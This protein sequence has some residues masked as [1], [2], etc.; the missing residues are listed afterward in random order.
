M[1]VLTIIPIKRLGEAK[2]RLSA[3]LDPSQRSARASSLLRSTV[4]AVHACASIDGLALISPDRAVLD[5]A[6]SLQATPIWQSA[7][8]LNDGLALGR[9]WAEQQGADA[10]LILLPDLP[11]LV[12]SELAAMVAL[13]TPGSVVLAPDRRDEGTNAML[14]NPPSA[15]A[16][17]F[18]GGS[19]ARHRLAAEAAGLRVVIH[20]APGLSFDLDTPDDLDELRYLR[21]ILGL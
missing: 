12:G 8:G 3:S 5:V 4:A 14:L 9:A 1:K 17:Q 10:L 11:M 20:R 18:E 15:I 13:T 7:G 21:P 6:A 19:Y 16:F 2:S